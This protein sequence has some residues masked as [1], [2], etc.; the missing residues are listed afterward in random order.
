MQLLV[1]AGVHFLIDMFAGMLPAIL[2][3]IMTEFTLSLSLGGILLV[4]LHMTSN[5]VQV[6]S[7]ILHFAF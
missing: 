2:P 6:S 7:T 4:V 1:L 5:G 3:A